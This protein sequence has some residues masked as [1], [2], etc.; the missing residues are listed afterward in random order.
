MRLPAAGGGVVVRQVTTAEDAPA[1]LLD[2]VDR[3]A[4]KEPGVAAYFL[5][6]SPVGLI[7]ERRTAL[8]ARVPEVVAT[9][10]RGLV[11]DHSWRLRETLAL[12]APAAVGAFARGRLRRGP[13]RV[14]AG[15]RPAPDPGRDRPRGGRSLAQRSRRRDGVGVA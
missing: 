8:A 6:G 13:G 5:A 1:A 9:G 2:W 4:E 15:R 12:R 10:L 7:D 14:P 11:D 3:R